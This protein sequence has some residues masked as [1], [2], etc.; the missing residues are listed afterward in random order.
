MK[1][2]V[3]VFGCNAF[4]NLYSYRVSIRYSDAFPNFECK[5]MVLALIVD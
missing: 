5:I 3:H 1:F 4:S 2:S